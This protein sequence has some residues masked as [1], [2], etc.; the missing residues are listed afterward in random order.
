MSVTDCAIPLGNNP[1]ALAPGD[2][3]Q[4]R[5]SLP[6]HLRRGRGGVGVASSSSQLARW[7][8]GQRLSWQRVRTDGRR[9]RGC[10]DTGRT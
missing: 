5:R 6:S 3:T 7:Q 8:P 1:R 10:D 2:A 4:R 9:R